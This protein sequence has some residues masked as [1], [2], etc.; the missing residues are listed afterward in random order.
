MFAIG[1]SYGSFWI[2]KLGGGRTAR[3]GPTAWR[4]RITRGRHGI[5]GGHWVDL[6]WLRAYVGLYGLGR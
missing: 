1:H 4:P 5:G 3:G 2:G 6:R